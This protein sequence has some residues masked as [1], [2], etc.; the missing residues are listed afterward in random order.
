MRVALVILIVVIAAV[1]AW[2]MERRRSSRALPVTTA[3]VVP[4][5]IDRDDFERPE[6]EWLVL[7]FSSDACESCAAMADRLAPLASDA[8]AVAE[9]EYGSD[10]SIHEK[11]GIDA[12]PAVG[13]YDRAGVAR[14]TFTGTTDS[15]TLWETLHDLRS[16]P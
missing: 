16:N 5:Q 15:A 10:R 3:A 2:F 4:P 6:A 8:V 7:L 12:V 13:F 11:Y 1:V 14:A 9:A